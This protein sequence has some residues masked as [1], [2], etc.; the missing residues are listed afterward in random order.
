MSYIKLSEVT[1]KRV[2]DAIFRRISDIPQTI[3]WNSKNGLALRNRERLEHYRNKHAGERC[4]IIGNGPSLKKTDLSLLKNE[5]SFGAN[6]LYL[7]F[8]EMDFRPTYYC[9]VNKLVQQQFG[10]DMEKLDMVKFFNWNCRNYFSDNDKLLFIK[11]KLALKDI[12]F[13]SDVTKQIGTGGTVT[14]A[15]LHLAYYMGFTKVIL[16]GC[17]HSFAE[18]GTPNKTISNN[19]DDVNHFHPDYFPKGALWQLP[20]FVKNEFAYQKVKTAFEADGREVVDATI[21]GKLQVFRKVD[22]ASLF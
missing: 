22:Y 2:I 14:I 12:G 19:R 18:K 5:E 9:S 13:Q 11:S 20:D 1:P 3:A 6:R 10:D 4:F 15:S 17:D 16:I 8:D 7:L 21:G